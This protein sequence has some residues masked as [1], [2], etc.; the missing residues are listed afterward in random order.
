MYEMLI[1]LEP[2]VMISTNTFAADICIV[3]L[4]VKQYYT[5]GV[6]LPDQ[7]IGLLVNE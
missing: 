2:P 6:V 1:T 5:I 3:S 7:P 4:T